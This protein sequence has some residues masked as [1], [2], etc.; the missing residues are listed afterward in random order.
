[1]SVR[2]HDG[3]VRDGFTLKI[4]NRSFRDKTVEVSFSGVAGALLK[5]PGAP[6]TPGP[7][8]VT[9]EAN[10][11]RAA[12]IFVIVPPTAAG[13][14]NTPAAFLVRDGKDQALAKT[15]FATGAAP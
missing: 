4:A 3:A 15:V 9:V 13:A 10:T 6:A 11:V 12:R 2:M 7:L 8:E 5:T 14:P 1:M